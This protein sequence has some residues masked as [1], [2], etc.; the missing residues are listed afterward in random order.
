MKIPIK[1]IFFSALK[2]S[3]NQVLPIV[4]LPYLMGRLGDYLFGVIMIAQT[5][6]M[7][8]VVTVEYGF[9]FTGV[10][11]V[12]LLKNDKRALGHLYRDINLVK[13]L[14]CAFCAM[15]V[16]AY[17][18]FVKPD[19]EISLALVM[20]FITVLGAALQ[21]SWFFMGLERFKVIAFAQVAGRAVCLMLLFVLV[22]EPS[23]Y[24]VAL[25]LFFLPALVSGAVQI[26]LANRYF[27][28]I[29]INKHSFDVKSL[30][31]VVCDGF[32]IY[33]SQIAATLFASVNTLVVGWF[34]G[35]AESGRYAFAEKIMRGV[36]VLSMPVTEA[37]FPR[38]VAGLRADAQSTLSTL[39]RLLFAGVAAYLAVAVVLSMSFDALIQML[40][41]SRAAQGQ[42]GDL[43]QVIAVVPALIYVNNLCG[44]QV[45]L[46][47]GHARVFRN[48]VAGSG[49]LLVGWS[50]LLVSQWGALG[51]AWALLLGELGICLG[52]VVL[53][54]KVIGRFWILR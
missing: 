49:V 53:S 1:N 38:V 27:F 44:T 47:L 48:V 42:I 6:A 28:D 50:L 23:D 9:N 46:G 7:F 39:R 14:F 12:A 4:V 32:D 33:V 31:K 11:Q 37:I 2:I 5:V 20:S 21:P 36:A 29:D 43:F 35:A 40:G 15:L 16:A 51:A 3:I 41:I 8:G 22:I 34:A 52:M 10:R 19:P 26:F 13:L 30:V 25:L 18:V 45:V 17:I 24:F 54:T